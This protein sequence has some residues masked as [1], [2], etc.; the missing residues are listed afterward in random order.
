[1]RNVEDMP[2]RTAKIGHS[3]FDLTN[4][5]SMQGIV[6][7]QGGNSESLFIAAMGALGALVS[8][9]GAVSKRPAGVNE[10]SPKAVQMEAMAR[11][12]NPETILFTA[13]VAAYMFQE[14]TVTEDDTTTRSEY[15]P[16]SVHHALEAWKKLTG[17]DPADYLI[18]GLVEADRQM[19]DGSDQK[20][21]EEFMAKRPGAYVSPA[22]GSVQ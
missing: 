15:S 22:S 12:V 10:N 9:S 18:S 14:V 17:K 11:M 4:K 7:A 6:V 13:L 8:G 1:M 5:A 3:M 19:F 21:L 16:V 20:L 2:E